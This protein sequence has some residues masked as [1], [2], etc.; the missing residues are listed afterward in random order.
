MS[1]Q[2][3]RNATRYGS[4]SSARGA[5][6]PFRFPSHP[7]RLS[8][9]AAVAIAQDPDVQAQANRATPALST[10]RTPQPTPATPMP[11]AIIVGFVT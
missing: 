4:R 8:R 9:Y 11:S 5:S 6:R 7:G 3:M 10:A 1:A 2:A